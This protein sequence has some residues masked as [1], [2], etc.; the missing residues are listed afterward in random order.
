MPIKKYIH[1]SKSKPLYKH[2]NSEEP[3]NDH[4]ITFPAHS[5]YFSRTGGVHT[6]KP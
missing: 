3:I 5:P 1:K 2:T 4:N 6:V